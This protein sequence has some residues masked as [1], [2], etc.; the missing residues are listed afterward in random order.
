MADLRFDE[1]PLDLAFTATR[2]D[3]RRR[4][5]VFGDP[6]D[7]FTRE[8]YRDELPKIDDVTVHTLLLPLEI[9]PDSD[10]LARLV[11]GAD[12]RAAA[13]SRLMLDGVEPAGEPD[14]YA[15]LEELRL[16]ARELSVDSTPTLVFEDGAMFAGAMPAA[17]IA[18]HLAG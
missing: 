14:R 16:A 4:I 9:Y 18:R 15:P 7:R 11:W 8:L 13:W 3:G 6:A 12:D 10:R 5:A 1:L 2:G 17:E